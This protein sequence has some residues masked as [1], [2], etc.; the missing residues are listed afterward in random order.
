[1]IRAYDIGTVHVIRVEV[2][3][4]DLD[5]STAL[6]MEECIR[7]RG[8]GYFNPAYTVTPLPGTSHQE[9][10]LQARRALVLWTKTL[11]RILGGTARRKR[12]CRR[13]SYVRRR[14]EFTGVLILDG[15]IM[16]PY[17]W[18]D[19]PFRKLPCHLNPVELNT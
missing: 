4:N 17:D 5:G 10:F 1:M 7:D 13:A 11:N 14:L 16:Q 6:R 3:W 8:T 12:Q 9:F 2:N 19:K 18:A 15:I